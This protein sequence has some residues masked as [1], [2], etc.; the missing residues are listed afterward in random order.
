MDTRLIIQVPTDPLLKLAAEKTAREQGFS[1]L[2][3]AIRV[4]MTQLAKKSLTI[5]FS[6]AA[7][8]EV[9]TA[10]QEKI[11]TKKYLKTKRE[12]SKGKGFGVSSASKMMENLRP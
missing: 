4:F 7:N 6:P 8:D 11:L 9:L 1:S 12:I 2:Q 3:E 5:S 10:R